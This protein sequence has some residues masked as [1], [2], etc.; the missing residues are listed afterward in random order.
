MISMGS[1]FNQLS[2]NAMSHGYAPESVF[3]AHYILS[4]LDE[5]CL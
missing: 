4:Y 5:L 2:E 1:I 3:W